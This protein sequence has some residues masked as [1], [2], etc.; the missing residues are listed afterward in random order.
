MYCVYKASEKTSFD[1]RVFTKQT[2]EINLLNN[3]IKTDN[4]FHGI[5]T[6]ISRLAILKDTLVSW[7]H[8][9]WRQVTKISKL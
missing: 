2:S 8:N 4:F 1:K 9:E 5:F 7:L 3:R 6:C